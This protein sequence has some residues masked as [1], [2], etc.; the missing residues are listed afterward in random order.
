MFQGATSFNQPLNLWNTEKA[1]SITN[2]IYGASSY[3][4]PVI[5]SNFTYNDLLL[6]GYTSAQLQALNATALKAASYTVFILLNLG[7]SPDFLLS[8]GF[9]GNE[10]YPPTDPLILNKFFRTTYQREGINNDCACSKN[11]ALPLSKTT[12]SLNTSTN[13]TQQSARM[14]CAQIVT[15]LGTTQP[16]T[17]KTAPRKTCSLGGPTFSY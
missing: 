16:V 15:S 12:N 17:V 14:R 4:Q 3:Y 8:I 1:T 10:V 9:S 11:Q 7:Y 2:M 5:I 6:A 13:Q